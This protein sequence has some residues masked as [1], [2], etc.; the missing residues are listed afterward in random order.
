MH[1]LEN[2]SYSP[3]QFSLSSQLF[4]VN[5]CMNGG[6]NVSLFS[7]CLKP[8]PNHQVPSVKGLRFSIHTS[9]SKMITLQ[10]NVPVFY[11]QHFDS[12]V[13]DSGRCDGATDGLQTWFEG[14]PA[15]C[16][17]VLPHAV[18]LSHINVHLQR[19]K[20]LSLH[21]DGAGSVAAV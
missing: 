7:T 19:G 20:L 9:F 13:H 18:T 14:P 21:V 1:S 4:A 8:S 6:N 3:F 10:N 2:R 11:R 16:C 12:S 15:L 17:S 5:K